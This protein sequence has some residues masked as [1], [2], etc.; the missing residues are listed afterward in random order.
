MHAQTWGTDVDDVLFG[1]LPAADDPWTI[2]RR[3]V[4]EVC[5]GRLVAHHR[6]GEQGCEAFARV[7]REVLCLE[8]VEQDL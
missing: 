2:P 5:H 7:G 3:G 8:A 1:Q 6:E 4:E